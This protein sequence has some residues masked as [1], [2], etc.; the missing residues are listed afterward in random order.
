MITREF[1]LYFTSRKNEKLWLD[2]QYELQFH[3]KLKP[4]QM[5]TTL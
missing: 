3:N 5:V 1:E 2:N 4:K